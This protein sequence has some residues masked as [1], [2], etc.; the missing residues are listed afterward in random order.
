MTIHEVLTGRV[1]Q[2]NDRG[3]YVSGDW[4]NLSRFAP[5]ELPPIGAMVRAAVDSKNFL[6]TLEVVDQDPPPHERAVR[7]EDVD[8]ARRLAILHAAAAFG[9]SRPDLKSGDVLRIADSWL[10]WVL[11]LDDA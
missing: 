4:R 6:I 8:T 2:R 10:L 1:E 9:A 5:L 3:I 11:G 7:E